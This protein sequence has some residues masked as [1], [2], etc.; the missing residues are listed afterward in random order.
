MCNILRTEKFTSISLSASEIVQNK[1]S[2]ET[3]DGKQKEGV[4]R[5]NET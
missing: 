5:I 1:K 4:S 3:K 2:K